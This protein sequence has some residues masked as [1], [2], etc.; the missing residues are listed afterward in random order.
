MFDNQGGDLSFSS[1]KSNRMRECKYPCQGRDGLCNSW[2]T[3]NNLLIRGQS[4]GEY[5]I[6]YVNSS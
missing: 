5:I 4:M 1:G 3:L 2:G 6:V